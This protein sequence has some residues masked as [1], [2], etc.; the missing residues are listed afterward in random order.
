MKR[1]YLV[2]IIFIL[3]L[4]GCKTKTYTVT[5]I[6]N[7]DI[8]AKVEVK[9]GNTIKNIDKPTKDG[10]IFLNWLKD[11]VEYNNDNPVTSDITLEASW[12]EIP[13]PVKTF[14]VTFDFG[15]EKK[16]VSVKEGEKATVPKDKPY[17][18]KYKF[19]GWYVGD[20]LYD[21]DSTIDKDILITAKF[22]KNRVMI[23]YDLDGGTG[24]IQVE[25]EKGT[26]PDRP[27]EPKKFGYTF[28]YWTINNEPYNFDKELFEDTKIKAIYE[29]NSYVKV[30]FNTDGGNE[31]PSQMLISGESI[32][33]LPIPVKEGYTFKYWTINGEKFDIN[34][35][36]TID[37]VLIAL[38]EEKE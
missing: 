20:T 13:N 12:T 3:I 1:K 8:L 19:L 6:D 33:T 18:E 31:I 4:T 35:K 14:Q 17:K 25:I 2:I 21:F 36:I 15:N 5:F 29:A 23:D 7:K 16:T 11:G 34:M 26:I 22:E 24:T 37:I 28:K 10:Y 32:K 30:T 27:K 38:Y 9:K